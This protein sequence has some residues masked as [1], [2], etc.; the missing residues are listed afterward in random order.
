MQPKKEQS[1]LISKC[2]NSSEGFIQRFSL[3]TNTNTVLFHRYNLTD[4]HEQTEI[5]LID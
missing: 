1:F 3:E 5:F 4:A 2:P